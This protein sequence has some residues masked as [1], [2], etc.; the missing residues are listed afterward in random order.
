MVRRYVQTTR[1]ESAQQTRRQILDAAREALLHEGGIDVGI[2]PIATRAG[3]ARS[4]IYAIFGSRSGLLSELADDTV[5]RA[6]VDTVIAEYMQADPVA[7]LERSL[8]ASCRMYDADRDTF[9]RLLVLGQVDADAAEPLARS[10]R[11]RRTGMN[12]LTARLA[13]AGKL[14]HDLDP[15]AAAHALSVL[16]TFWAFDELRSGRGLSADECGD[17]LVATARATLLAD[18]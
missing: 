3:V 2:G 5:H 17:V 11:D 10:D 14:R 6:G 8:R 16:T 12:V 18:G 9:A 7:A 13:A 15:T 1:A 4:T